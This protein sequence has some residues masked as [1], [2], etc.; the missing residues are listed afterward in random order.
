MNTLENPFVVTGYCGKKYFCDRELESTM[1]LDALRNQRNVVLSAPRKMGKTG[2]IHQVFE[3]VKSDKNLTTIYLDIFSTQC[4]A[5]FV[6][7]FASAVIGKLD[8]GSQKAISQIGKFFSGLKPTFGIDTLTGLPQVSV[9]VT[10]E[11]KESS[12]KDVFEYLK[13]SQK[14]CFI[15]IDE[16]QQIATYPEKGV[17]ALLRSYIQFLPNV[18]FIFAGSKQ[19]LLQEMFCSAKRPFYQS[20]QIVSISQINN[21]IYYK[22]A[23]SFFEKRNRTLPKDVFMDLYEKFDGYTWYLQLVLNRLYSVNED[24][25]KEK[26]GLMIS[27]I[28]TEYT[29]FYQQMLTTIPAYYSH[30]LR[31]IAE[32]NCVTEITSGNF[33][34]KYRLKAASS[35]RSALD[36]LLLLELVYKTDNGYI[37]YDRFMNEWLKTR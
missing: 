9:T 5:D 34:A 35:V 15:A 7:L 8:T 29:Y 13:Q 37:V 17:E 3:M 6:R 31:A 18:H 16:F 33:I 36:K 20:A 23:Q 10:E 19:H 28:I 14:E 25:T 26:V 32:E 1:I 21:E 12:L 11:Q 2:L 30:L 22:F 27:Q 4:L 24:I